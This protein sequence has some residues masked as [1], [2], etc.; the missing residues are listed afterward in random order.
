M[1][2]PLAGFGYQFLPSMGRRRDWLA[3]PVWGMLSRSAMSKLKPNGLQLRHN[4]LEL[5]LK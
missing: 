2:L 5:T 1:D 3:S 4:F